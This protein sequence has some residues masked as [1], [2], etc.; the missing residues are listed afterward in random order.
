MNN[1]HDEK[2]KSERE[3]Q[4][5]LCTSQVCRA[6]HSCA[7]CDRS[8]CDVLSRRVAARPVAVWF[9]CLCV[10]WTC[11]WRGSRACS[12]G[13]AV[14][15]RFLAAVAAERVVAAAAA[16]AAAAQR[17]VPAAAGHAQLGAVLRALLRS[18]LG[19][20]DHAAHDVR[21]APR[22]VAHCAAGGRR[23]GA[24]G[25]RRRGE[26]SVG[27]R[28]TAGAGARAAAAR[29]RT[30]CRSSRTS[31]SRKHRRPRPG[32]PGSGRGGPR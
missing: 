17:V 15:A 26:V 20:A 6:L 10:P 14:I 11:M 23:A 7:G 32:A 9:V 18:A 24:A 1:R 29:R 28:G 31:G 3:R 16:A 22:A 19:V 2:Y 13:G 25:G 27:A 5:R 8:C 12:C 21:A 30:Y 4:E